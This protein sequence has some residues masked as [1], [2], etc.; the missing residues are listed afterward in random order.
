MKIVTRINK[1]K[2]RFC[3][4]CVVSCP[5]EVIDANYEERKAVVVNQKECIV[6]LNCEEVC[7]TKA[8]TVEGVIRRDWPAP[9]IKFDV[10]GQKQ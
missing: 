3:L 1:E 7:P 9:P 10:W 4:D 5:V 2:C 8:I 6:C